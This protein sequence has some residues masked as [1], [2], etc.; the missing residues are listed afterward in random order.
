MGVFKLNNSIYVEALGYNCKK[1]TKEIDRAA[2]Q[3]LEQFESKIIEKYQMRS[4]LSEI[5]II[6]GGYY[7]KVLDTH[8]I[9]KR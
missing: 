4:L 8:L 6:K 5:K 9:Q 1:T 7:K 3:V 2:L